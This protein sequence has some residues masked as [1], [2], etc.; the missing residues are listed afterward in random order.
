MH[1]ER[2][3]QRLHETDSDPAVLSLHIVA[4]SMGCIVTR[5]ALLDNLPL[6]L[7][8]VVM[9]C[10]PNRGSHVATRFSPLL[11]RLCRTMVEIA[12]LP[13]SWVNRLP[14]TLP[15][16]VP[17]GII[18]A[19]GD[20]VVAAESTDLP[21]VIDRQVIPGMHSGILFK[22]ATAEATIHFLRSGRFAP[23]A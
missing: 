18:V 2:L 4:H 1:A 5:Q 12:D 8:K 14:L 6:K 3:K 7:G 10:P 21:G 23:T 15:T 9:L 17:V 16:Q 11:G 20:L 19:S 13:D 22:Q